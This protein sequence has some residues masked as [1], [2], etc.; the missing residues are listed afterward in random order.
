MI[1]NPFLTQAFTNALIESGCIGEERGWEPLLFDDSL[2]TYA[3]NH[4]YGEYIFDWSWAEA[5]KRHRLNYYPKLTSMIPFTPVTTKHFLKTD[6]QAKAL[7]KHEEYYHERPFSSAHFLFLHP[8]EKDLFQQ[9][10]YL[11][12]ESLQY[13]WVNENFTTFDAYLETFKTKK[14]KNVRKERMFTDLEFRRYTGN[15]LTVDHAKRMYQ[16]YI[17]TIMNK[18][19]YDYLNESFFKNIFSDMPEKILYIEASKNDSP[20]AGS[21]FFYDE[22]KLYG[23][24]WGATEYVENLHFELCYYQGIDFCIEKNIAVFEAGAQGEHKIARGF[25]PSRIYSGHKIK[26]P[27]FSQAIATFI[28]QEKIMVAEN[29]EVLNSYLP[30][31]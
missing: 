11:I 7:L 1:Q 17:S 9:N 8:Q 2:F 6:N 12:R 29:I 27:D 21:L 16:F 25:R 3:K 26:H 24:Y 18:N 19:S 31:K 10:A 20:I 22:Q 15:D 13:H 4:S 5:F 14:A 30:F 23:R 28:D